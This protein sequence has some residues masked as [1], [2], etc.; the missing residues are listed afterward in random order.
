MVCTH[1]DL[2]NDLNREGGLIIGTC[3][4]V[5]G[6]CQYI[7][8]FPLAHGDWFT[9]TVQYLIQDWFTVQYLIQ[10]FTL[11]NIPSLNPYAPPCLLS[12]FRKFPTAKTKHS[13]SVNSLE[14]FSSRVAC[15]AKSNVCE[16]NTKVK[17]QGTMY[18]YPNSILKKSHLHWLV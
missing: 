14:C 15:Q 9:V 13:T 1:W 5:V 7:H 16:R 8:H 10:D 3:F 12:A 18:E 4:T 17:M 11:G 2:D 6:D